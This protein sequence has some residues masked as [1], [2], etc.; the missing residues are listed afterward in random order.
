MAT[1]TGQVIVYQKE[2]Y[3]WRAIPWPQTCRIDAAPASP[4]PVAAT[5]IEIFDYRLQDGEFFLN[6]SWQH[7]TAPHGRIDQYQ[8]RFMPQEDGEEASVI[9]EC[10]INVSVRIYGILLCV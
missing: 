4:S 6:I 3:F 9:Y 10:N 8:L 7:P 2:E 1:T 5:T